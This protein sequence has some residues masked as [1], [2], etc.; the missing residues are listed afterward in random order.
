MSRL[1]KP[2][3]GFWIR[4]CVVMIYPFVGLLYKIR[5]SGLDRVPGPDRGGVIIAVNHISH[6]DT[7]LTARLVWQSGRVPRFMI[8]ASLFHKPVTGPIFRGSHQIPV[9]R[10]TTDAAQSL[11]DAV[12]AL[13]RGEAIVIYPE[14]TITRDPQQWPM[15]AKT[16][17]ARLWQLRPETPVIPI[18]QWGAQKRPFSPMRLLRRPVALASVGAPVDLDRFRG[19]EPTAGTL[20]EITDA[21]MAAVRDEVATLRRLPAPQ[22][23]FRVEHDRVDPPAGQDG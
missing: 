19:S 16:G 17:I 1:H 14:G 11:R 7:L 13:E 20:R 10:G 4:L 18:G 2:K 15:H 9:Y 12:D 23:F 3:A 5:W 22:A 6:I 8:K 21:I